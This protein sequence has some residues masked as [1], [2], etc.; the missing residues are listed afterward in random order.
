ME[1]KCKT[2]RS[3]CEELTKFLA[4]SDDGV[5]YVGHASILAQIEGKKILFDAVYEQPPYLNSWL[6]FPSQVQDARLFDVDMV[7]ISHCHQDHFDL[8]FLRQLKPSTRIVIVGGRP[9]FKLLFA[10]LIDRVEEVPAGK[11]TELFP[12]VFTYPLLHEYNQIDSSMIVKGRHFSVYHGNDNFISDSALENAI[13]TTGP[14]DVGCVPFGFIH[15]YPFLLDG[16]DKTWRDEEGQRL[17]TKYLDMGISAGK[18]LKA[19]IIIPFGANLVY[20]DD[21]DSVMNQAVLSPLDFSLY[22]K[23]TAAEIGRNVFPLFARDFIHKNPHG[24]LDLQWKNLNRDDYRSQMQLFLNQHRRLQQNSTV[25]LTETLYK[26]TEWISKR[27]KSSGAPQLPHQLLIHSERESEPTLRIDLRDHTVQL[28]KQAIADLPS[29]S[30]FVQNIALE[31]WLTQ[32]IKFE[33]VI[34][35]RR[36]RIRREPNLYNLPVLEVLHNHL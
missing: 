22:A 4:H 18:A 6:F 25:L 21:V 33:E 32:T 9:Q 1:T 7:V 30:F 36:F 24:E 13:E 17:I 29:T 12:K 26:N 31:G 16:V 15:W 35:S 2:P 20:Y 34:G 10:E 11:L 28:E 8:E 23:Q 5:F 3:E 14:V 27:L 19:S